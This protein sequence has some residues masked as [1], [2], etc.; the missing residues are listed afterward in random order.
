MGIVFQ[1]LSHGKA[2][3]LYYIMCIYEEDQY[4]SLFLQKNLICTVL[5]MNSNS[6]PEMQIQSLWYRYQEGNPHPPQKG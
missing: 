6:K 1:Y 5:M 2:G 3:Y 4:W